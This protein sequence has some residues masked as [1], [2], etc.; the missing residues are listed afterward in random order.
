MRTLALSLALAVALVAVP[1]SYQNR[2]QAATE[3]VVWPAQYSYGTPSGAFTWNSTVLG[4]RFGSPLA[5]H[6][7]FGA[8]LYYGSISNLALGGSGLNGFTGSSLAG[9]LSL[10]LGTNV[11]LMDLGVFGGY[12]A[13]GLTANGSTPSD[14]VL[15]QTSGVR[16]GADIKVRLPNG[17]ALRGAVTFLPSLNSSENMSLSSPPT[18]A[19]F[20]GTGSGTEYE[21]GVGYSLPHFSLFVGYRSGNYQTNWSGDGSSPTTFSG[22]VFS[23]ES[24]F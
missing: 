6:L 23:L 16:T 22:Y 14:R 1:Y 10:R 17:L 13:F 20:N 18:V 9:D 3:F 11:G 19:Q 7:G 4:L 21:V 8:G 24:R 15:L 12:Q 2:V 5:P